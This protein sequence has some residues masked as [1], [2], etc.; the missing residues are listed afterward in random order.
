VKFVGMLMTFPHTKFHVLSANGLFVITVNVKGK[1]R[2]KK[3]GAMLLL[4]F[5]K[6]YFATITKITL[7][8]VANF[9]I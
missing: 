4:T 1:K 7:T 3:H 8:K 6:N 2:R 5:Y 9:S